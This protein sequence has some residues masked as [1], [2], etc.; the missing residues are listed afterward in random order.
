MQVLV[1][2]D[3][4]ALARG[5]ARIFR[6]RGYDAHAA[7]SGAELLAALDRA[8]W[9]VVVLD[10]SLGDAD[11]L[12]LVRQVRAR[13]EQVPF[14]MLTGRCEPEDVV[15]ALD[16]GADD[17]V[18]KRELEPAVLVAR[19]VALARRAQAPRPHRRITAG[20]FVVDEATRTLTVDGEE[21]HLAPT[22]LRIVVRLAESPG[23]IVPRAVLLAAGWGPTAEVSGNA[24]D[25]ALKRVRSR[26]GRWSHAIR[27]VRQR[28]V[29]LVGNPEQA[30]IFEAE[31]CVPDPGPTE[32]GPA[33]R[34]PADSGPAEMRPAEMGSADPG[35]ADPGSADP[36]SADPG[37]ADPGSA[38]P[39]SADSGSDTK[40]PEEDSERPAA[41]V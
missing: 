18:A 19:A 9:D 29:A 28:G 33:D 34:A 30:L 32:E 11:G 6:D 26:L 23:R 35:S 14:L 10:W 4:A 8:R 20:N 7:G 39:G 1:I 25:T 24:L 27:S 15:A 41:G 17:F 36:G 40:R 3:E 38:D 21:I 37:S 2:D 13:G 16:A 5:I 12:D 22:E 31:Q